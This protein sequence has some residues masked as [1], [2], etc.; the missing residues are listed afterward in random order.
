VP[1]IYVIRIPNLSDRNNLQNELLKNGIQTGF[2]YQPNHT[3]TYFKNSN[4][5]GLEITE[6]IFPELLTLPMHEDLTID[7]VNYICLNLINY[8]Q[9]N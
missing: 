7:E 5:G 2:H 4:R 1:H 6:K 8:L 9:N 3:H